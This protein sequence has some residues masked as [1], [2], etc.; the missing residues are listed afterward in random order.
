MTEDKE[1]GGG[2]QLHQSMGEELEEVMMPI[3]PRLDT[4]GGHGG[5][6]N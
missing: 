2:I 6:N 3:E 1:L 4:R 5:R